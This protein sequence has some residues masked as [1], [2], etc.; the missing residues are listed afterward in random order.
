MKKGKN[1]SNGNK[2]LDALKKLEAKIRARIAREKVRQQ[3]LDE[4]EQDRVEHIVGREAV[5]YAASDP[6]FVE[7]LKPAL[8]SVTVESEKK[9]LQAWGLL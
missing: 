6:K 5:A 3:K 9:L 8:Q 2:R 7:V 4:K 1:G